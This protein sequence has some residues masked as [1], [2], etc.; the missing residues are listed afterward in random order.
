VQDRLDLP[1]ITTDVIVGFPGETDA[2][3]NETLATSRAV[4]FSK[5]HIFPFSARR[6]TPAADM[7]NQVPKHVQQIRSRELAAVEKELREAYYGRLLGRQLRVLVESRL[8]GAEREAGSAVARQER[9]WWT[10][11]ACRYATVELP[12]GRQAEGRFVEVVAGETC[13]E[14]IIAADDE[15]T[16]NC[17]P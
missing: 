17:R 9:G 3:F 14:R 11:T 7:Q 13:G 16:A 10:G 6:G 2:E 15:R 1:A 4:G 8:E 12:A 5:I